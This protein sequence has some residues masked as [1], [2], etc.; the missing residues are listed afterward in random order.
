MGVAKP[1]KLFL[2]PFWMSVL[3]LSLLKSGDA[4]WDSMWFV[5]DENVKYFSR[6]ICMYYSVEK[7][8]MHVQCT[9]LS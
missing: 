8:Y 9:A 4:K 3:C 7:D 6:T 2:S 1:I 5:L